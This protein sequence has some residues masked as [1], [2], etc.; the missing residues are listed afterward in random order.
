MKPAIPRDVVIMS[1]PLPRNAIGKVV[2]RE[3]EA[4]G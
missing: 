2:K 4:F 1:A 3:L